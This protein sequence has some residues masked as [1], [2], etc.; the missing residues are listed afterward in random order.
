MRNFLALILV[1][2]GFVGHAQNINNVQFPEIVRAKERA[3]V[4][5][6]D[7]LGYKIMKC[8][9]HIH[10]VFS[11]GLV[12]PTIRVEEAWRDGLDAIAI[13]DHIE[14]R[15]HSKFVVGDFN[16]P[17]DLALPKADE[18]GIMLV[19]AGE[20]TRSMPP[21]HL[22]AL[23][24]DDVNT[25]ERPE[26]MDAIKAAKSGGAFI[27]WNHPG[28]KAQQPDTCMW[29]DYHEQLLK[30]GL[31]HGIEVFNEQEWYPVALDWCLEKG[32]APMANS[33]IHDV[34]AY[35]YDYDKSRRP[36]TLVLVKDRTPEAL[37][38]ALMN[39]RTVAFFAGKLAGK[40]EYLD[41]IFQQSIKITP[42]G[43]A[44]KGER[45]RIT[46]QSDIPFTLK[47]DVN[48]VLEPH[49]SVA[50]NREKG[51]AAVSV[52]NLFTG[53]TKCLETKLTF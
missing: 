31:M 20:I 28:W 38:E 44:K 52:T 49:K 9:F 37:K 12:W 26:P 35:L 39:G 50:V 43:K 33:D 15:P 25:L 8:D 3:E 29:M 30:A 40:P 46:N 51:V 4:I 17:Y 14:Y 7:V 23:F 13:T 45:Y 10:T 48:I 2:C 47:G 24:I 53:S 1:L 18:L 11:D 42:S 5:I 21:G 34:S 6:P 41:A 27:Q 32:M 16:T 19:K 22:N 36:M